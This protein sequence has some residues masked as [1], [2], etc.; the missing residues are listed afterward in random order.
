MTKKK[1]TS[2]ERKKAQ[3]ALAFAQAWHFYGA[4]LA[5]DHELPTHTQGQPTA[6]TEC[7]IVALGPTSQEPLFA[8]SMKAD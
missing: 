5:L 1:T 3:R 2:E 6:A 8:V 7:R 4:L